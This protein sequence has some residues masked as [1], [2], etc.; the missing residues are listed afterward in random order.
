VAFD[1][2]TKGCFVA[3]LGVLAEQLSIGAVLHLS[4]ILPARAKSDK[5]IAVW[6]GPFWKNRMVLRTGVSALRGSKLR[7]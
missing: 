6:D 5:M 4:I 3:A 7:W 1:D 2:F